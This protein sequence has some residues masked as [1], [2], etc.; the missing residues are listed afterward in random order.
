MEMFVVME[1]GVRF[2]G[3]RLLRQSHRFS[4]DNKRL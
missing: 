3:K 2:F 1:Q 4:S